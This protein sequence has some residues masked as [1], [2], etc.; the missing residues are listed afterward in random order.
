M[1]LRS[2]LAPPWRRPHAKVVYGHRYMLDIP[3]TQ[4]DPLRGE[5]LLTCLALQSLIRRRDVL[6]PRRRL[7][8]AE[9]GIRGE[10]DHA[11]PMTLPG[12]RGRY[13]MHGDG[14]ESLAF[15]S[16]Q[17]TKF[18]IADAGGIFQHGPENRLERAGRM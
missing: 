6:Q 8:P 9:G 13:A 1:S 16:P 5:R 17:K 4:S 11:L 2:A 18:S 3:G 12:Q 14:T 10:L 7:E 15:R